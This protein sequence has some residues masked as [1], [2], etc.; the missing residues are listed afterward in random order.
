MIDGQKVGVD[1]NLSSMTALLLVIT[2]LVG[3]IVGSRY[4]QLHNG[5]KAVWH[6]LRSTGSLI[7]SALTV[8]PGVVHFISSFWL[9]EEYPVVFCNLQLCLS[10]CCTCAAFLLHLIKVTPTN[11][12]R[13]GYLYFLVIHL[14]AFFFLTFVSFLLVLLLLLCTKPGET[15]LNGERKHT[16]STTPNDLLL[17]SYPAVIMGYQA[18]VLFTSSV[19]A[20]KDESSTLPAS[21]TK[22]TS[23]SGRRTRSSS[24]PRRQRSKTPNRHS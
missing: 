18:L 4:Q 23:N 16:N 2:F 7:R 22:K 14:G 6:R 9:N 11:G 10:V 17:M 3:Y 24:K 20:E 8:F 21:P 1:Y 5:L 13:G 15:L 19:N 12:P